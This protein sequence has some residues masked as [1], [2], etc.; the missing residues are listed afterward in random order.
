MANEK[1][2]NS[3]IG[4]K[5]DSIDQLANQQATPGSDSNFFN[6]LEDQVNGAI[7]DDNTEVT[8]Q[9][10]PSGSEQVTRPQEPAAGSKN[11]KT[12]DNDSNP[13]KKRYT[14]SS[15]EAIT[16]K[17]QLNELKP[18]VP[19]LEAMKQDSGL[20]EHV[21][22]Y[23]VNGGAP[24]K[25]VQE[26]LGL[27]EDFEFDQQEAMSNPD[28]DS[29]KVMNAHVD[30]LVQ[31]RVGQML[32][33]EKQNAAQVQQNIKKKQEELAFKK[34]HRMSDEEFAKFV[35]QAKSHTLT[36]DD[37]NYL[38]N[39]DQAATNTAKSTKKDMLK[40]MKN[41]RTIPTSASGANSQKQPESQD[42]KVFDGIL[43]LDEGMDK[44]FG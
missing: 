35:N 25:T 19:V 41:V 36:L 33:Q 21:R 16:L 8:Q 44:L 4:M 18:F 1:K 32:Q 3:E 26:Q 39:R 34:K 7:R 43:G 6:A 28:S 37:V 14:D 20:V 27:G 42:D 23:L 11:V 40:Q 5:A 38:L 13:Y 24:A 22:G 2:G 31:Q 10:Q 30:G 12:W 17:E 15:R 9:Q 29:A